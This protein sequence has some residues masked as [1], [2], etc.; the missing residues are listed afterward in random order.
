MNQGIVN[1]VISAVI[2]GVVGAAVMF[3]GGSSSPKYKELTVG[4]LVI[5]EQATLKNSKDGKDD[6][7]IKEGSVLAN[8]VVLGKKF[9]GTQFQGHVFVANRML[10]TPDDL[11]AAPMDKWRFCT[12]IGSSSVA[13]G[14]IV[15]RSADGAAFV[16]QKIVNGV[17]IRTGFDEE[18]NPQIWAFQN[19]NKQFSKVSFDPSAKQLQLAANAASGTANAGVFNA[20]NVAPGP[21]AG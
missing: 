19:A 4:K 14:E 2:G 10:T 9:I 7:V 13:G 16:G 17:L 3:F 8:N 18:S 12:E 15:V 5:E 20:A 6:V 1:T 11:I 21:A